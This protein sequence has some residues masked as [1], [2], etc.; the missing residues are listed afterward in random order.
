MTLLLAPLLLAAG[1]ARAAQ[2]AVPP[3][4]DEL[5]R[6]RDNPANLAQSVEQLRLE[7]KTAPDDAGLLWRL[8]RAL[9]AQAGAVK[10]KGPK[11]ERLAQAAQVLREAAAKHPSDA[12]SHYWLAREMADENEIRRTL[13]LAKSMKSELETAISQDPRH[14]DARQLLCEELHQLPGFFGGD[15]KRAV[16]ECEEALRLTPNET[17]RYPALAEAYLAVKRKD[18]AVAALKRVF[19][20]KRPDDPVS[21]PRDLEDARAL[22]KKLTGSDQPQP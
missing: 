1:F 21:A 3:S 20:I 22:L 8:G 11:L 13:G 12:Q 4:A 18:D 10:E 19:L 14:A 15:K 2:P 5:Y 7:L 9:V 6:K 16:R 17:S